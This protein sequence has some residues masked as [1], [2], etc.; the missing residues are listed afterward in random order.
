MAEIRVI[1]KKKPVKILDELA[2]QLLNDYH[3]CD[4]IQEQVKAWNRFRSELFKNSLGLMHCLWRR[5]VLNEIIE[6]GLINDEEFVSAEFED[7]FFKR[8]KRFVQR[9]KQLRK[10]FIATIASE[11]VRSHIVEACKCFLSVLT[12][13][14]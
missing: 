10:S 14:R 7:E 3:N 11:R 12:K 6:T 8:K 1:Y 4:S 2:D 9:F 13:P 5:D